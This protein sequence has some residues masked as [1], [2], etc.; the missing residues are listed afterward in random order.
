MTSFWTALSVIYVCVCV[1]ENVVPNLASASQNSK[2][3]MARSSVTIKHFQTETQSPTLL[4]HRP[5]STCL[6]QHVACRTSPF[7][8]C[9]TE[10]KLW[11]VLLLNLVTSVY[12]ALRLHE[13]L[14][15]IHLWRKRLNLGR[16]CSVRNTVVKPR[17]LAFNSHS[18]PT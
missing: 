4:Q 12:I 11:W 7:T 6:L 5:S 15:G 14:Q 13:D 18:G 1:C 2:L 8:D 10:W 9:A 16:T 17:L 3:C